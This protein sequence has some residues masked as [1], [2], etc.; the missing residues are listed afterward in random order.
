MT[1]MSCVVPIV[2]AIVLPTGVPAAPPACCDGCGVPS[3]S[4]PSI[5]VASCAATVPS[6]VTA[7]VA[8][9]GRGLKVKCSK[10][11]PLVIVP[12]LG[13]PPVEVTPAPNVPHPVPVPL[14]LTAVVVI[15][16][17]GAIVALDPTPAGVSVRLPGVSVLPLL[18]QRT[19]VIDPAP[20]VW[21]V[22]VAAVIPVARLGSNGDGTTTTVGAVGYPAPGL[23]KVKPETVPDAI[24]AQPDA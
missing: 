12:T 7:A 11:G 20:T 24:L 10:S 1:M 22:M 6:A 2:S 23:L 21:T 19:A 4:P 3:N 15:I 14:K 13:A 17:T 5:M 16:N 9:N 8:C 18:V